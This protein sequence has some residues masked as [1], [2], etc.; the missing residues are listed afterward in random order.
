MAKIDQA[1]E[2]VLEL[3]AEF[4]QFL[5]E[6]VHFFLA[7]LEFVNQLLDFLAMGGIKAFAFLHARQAFVPIPQFRGEYCDVGQDRP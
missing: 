3:D 1:G 4:S 6:V 7:A 5:L 2:V